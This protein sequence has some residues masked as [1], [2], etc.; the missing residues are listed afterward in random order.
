MKT[1]TALLF[2]LLPLALTSCGGEAYDV[3][4]PSIGNVSNEA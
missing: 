2:L 1:K 4:K 3:N